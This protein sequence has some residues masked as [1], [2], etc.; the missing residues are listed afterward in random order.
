MAIL[1]WI[2]VTAGITSVALLFGRASLYF[3]I[4]SFGV[5][6]ANFATMCLQY[7]EPANRA[8]A[9]MRERLAHMKPGYQHSEEFQR[10]QSSTPKVLPEDRAL[11]WDVLTV[12]NLVSGV[13]ALGLCAY[14]LMLM[15]R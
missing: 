4:G 9:R 2:F 10:A 15:M 6:F 11:R 1:K 3:M 7:E 5:A 12:I 13:A 14:G 8:R